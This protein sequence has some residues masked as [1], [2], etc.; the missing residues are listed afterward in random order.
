MKSQAGTLL[1]LMIGGRGQIKCT[2][3]EISRFFKVAGL[4]LGHSIMI[5]VNDPPPLKLGT[6]AYTKNYNKHIARYLKK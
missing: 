5:I 4:I 1:Y 2:R 6:K 3:G